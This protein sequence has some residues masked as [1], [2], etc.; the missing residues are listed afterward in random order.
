MTTNSI[1]T[2]AGTVLIAQCQANETLLNIDKFVFAYIDGLDIDSQ[3]PPTEALPDAGDIVHQRNVDQAGYVSAAAVVYSTLLG[4]DVG[5]FTFNWIGLYCS[6]HA[7][8]VAVSYVPIQT[9]TASDG[10]SLGNS[11]VKNIGIQFNNAADLTGINIAADSWQYDFTTLIAQATAKVG[12]PGFSFTDTKPENTLWLDGSELPVDADYDDLDDY[13]DGYY[14][15]GP[16]GRSYLP[17]P[18]GYFL[19]IQD[20]GR[21]VDPDAAT[22]TDRGDGTTGDNVGTKQLDEFESHNHPHGLDI[23]SDGLQIQR[24][25]GVNDDGNETGY[26]GGAETRPKNINIRMYVYYK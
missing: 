20:Q 9:K 5:D 11:L 1:I 12:F 8:L 24:N 3:P 16:N 6:E 7:T 25:N 4:P 17:E 22:R 14:G 18:Q 2:A 15:R 23:T 10:F 19:R 26:T 21:G 13:F